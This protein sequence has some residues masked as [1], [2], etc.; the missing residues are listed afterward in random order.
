LIENK[1]PYL[2]FDEYD[3]YFFAWQATE[4]DIIRS[5]LE[6]STDPEIG[7]EDILTL[8]KD[9]FADSKGNKYKIE[10]TGENL[11]EFIEV[12]EQSTVIRKKIRTDYIDM[13]IKNLEQL[14]SIYFVHDDKA[15]D[16]FFKAVLQD[17]DTDEK[18]FYISYLSDRISDEDLKNYLVE[19]KIKVEIINSLTELKKKEKIE[20]MKVV[21][22]NYLNRLADYVTKGDTDILSA[23]HIPDIET[24]LMA[25]KTAITGLLGKS[26]SSFISI[27]KQEL[28]KE[29]VA[30]TLNYGYV[31]NFYYAF[32]M[33]SE[34]SQK[35]FITFLNLRIENFRLYEDILLD[36]SESEKNL[37]A[38]AK[39]LDNFITNKNLFKYLLYHLSKGFYENRIVLNKLIITQFDKKGWS[40]KGEAGFPDAGEEP[41][42][43]SR[44]LLAYYIAYNDSYR[45]G[46]KSLE[47]N[48]KFWEVFVEPPEVKNEW[49]EYIQSKITDN[50]NLYLELKAEVSAVT[51]FITWFFSKA[52]TTPAFDGPE[53]KIFL[54]L[55]FDN[56]LKTLSEADY[57]FSLLDTLKKRPEAQSFFSSFVTYAQDLLESAVANETNDRK[58]QLYKLMLY[59]ARTDPEKHIPE[60][61]RHIAKEYE[62]M[63]PDKEEKDADL[64]DIFY[65]ITIHLAKKLYYPLEY[66]EQ[67]FEKILLDACKLARSEGPEYDK[68][69]LILI[70]LLKDVYLD[71]VEEEK[72]SL[73][74]VFTLLWEVMGE[75]VVSLEKIR[76][77]VENI[78]DFRELLNALEVV[79]G[80]GIK[81]YLTFLWTD[82]Y[83]NENSVDHEKI[84]TEFSHVIKA[85]N[86]FF[87]H[88]MD[89]SAVK[90]MNNITKWLADSD[91]TGISVSAI[92]KI[93]FYSNPENSIAIAEE[94]IR[95]YLAYIKFYRETNPGAVYPGLIA[96]V[97][98]IYFFVNRKNITKLSSFFKTI[99]AEYSEIGFD[100][101][102]LKNNYLKSILILSNSM[103]LREQIKEVL[104]G[105][106]Y[107]NFYA[108]LTESY[109]LNNDPKIMSFIYYIYGREKFLQWLSVDAHI[110]LIKENFE[111]H[112]FSL[113]SLFE[114]N[115]AADRADKSSTKIDSI[116]RYNIIFSLFLNNNQLDN[117]LLDSLFLFFINSAEIVTGEFSKENLFYFSKE[118]LIPTNTKTPV[119]TFSTTHEGLE[120]SWFDF[121]TRAVEYFIKK[122][123][124]INK[125]NFACS[126]V[127]IKASIDYTI[128]KMI[129]ASS[130]HRD[131]YWE[132]LKEKIYEPVFRGQFFQVNEESNIDK[133]L[134]LKNITYDT[135]KNK[136]D[137]GFNIL[138]SRFIVSWVFLPDKYRYFSNYLKNFVVTYFKDVTYQ[139]ESND[140]FYKLVIPFYDE[141]KI[142][143]GGGSWLEKIYPS[144][145]EFVD[146]PDTVYYLSPSINKNYVMRKKYELFSYLVEWFSY[147]DENRM[148]FNLMP[149]IFISGE[150]NPFITSDNKKIIS[151]KWG[152][153]SSSFT[154]NPEEKQANTI[155][156]NEYFPLDG[157]A[158]RVYFLDSLT[159]DRGY[160]KL[161][162]VELDEVK[163][164]FK[165]LTSH[166]E[167]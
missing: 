46:E 9:G 77:K 127:Y 159:R 79:K 129:L 88:D 123:D 97:S 57:F 131:M 91:I 108:E 83:E 103:E 98:Y 150:E 149:K 75:E 5:L 15:W 109:T 105:A 140:Y 113:K 120:W 66:R 48:E 104:S 32:L 69:R 42:P 166:E 130:K 126:M 45:Q 107:K 119:I 73:S 20:N 147:N 59:F 60:I 28:D 110:N 155:E 64:E 95:F 82:I 50:Y 63:I 74:K 93:I 38:G 122:D 40:V 94:F 8:A 114:D 146:H 137:N 115:R 65:N 2:D 124:V 125:K 161:Q 36:T 81:R 7:I 52:D 128:K 4:F 14:K 96:D 3:Y 25:F 112:Y 27:L 167:E 100:E 43:L 47:Y 89:M 153:Y 138:F 35:E 70:S 84:K 85:I 24:E 10:I 72:I 152:F 39:V 30:G 141:V 163:Y 1:S 19:K 26:L 29:P 31:W 139:I 136:G 118:D 55:Y 160:Y 54:T 37:I 16:N 102:D 99:L 71:L 22:D 154:V 23:S 133:V 90:Y 87:Y 68:A 11:K 78:Q 62:K 156:K 92:I 134:N 145:D 143:L 44:Q 61:F 148:Y 80:K 144:F 58:F 164:N 142:R 106:K 116:I 132:R 6:S 56:Y 49:M 12:V 135:A 76:D 157:D 17:A 158:S 111:T 21:C 101:Y 13:G 151:A 117:T 53:E 67:E 41:P 121:F 165:L 51:Y 33:D 34:I 86:N 18:F 162:P